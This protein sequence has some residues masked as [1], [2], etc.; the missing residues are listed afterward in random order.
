MVVLV[1]IGLSFGA[2]NLTIQSDDPVDLIRKEATRFDRLISLLIEEAILR[3]EDFGIE[4]GAREYRFL[5]Y[6]DG[7]WTPIDNDKVLRP[8]EL[9]G[10]VELDL[11]VE[12]SLIDFSTS[13]TDDGPSPQVFVLSSGEITP[14]FSAS[15]FIPTITTRYIVKGNFDGNQGASIDE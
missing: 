9:E 7:E 14:E 5:R 13:I 6:L 1:I 12:K 10:E 15:F 3:G 2:I 4:F 8:R 11:A